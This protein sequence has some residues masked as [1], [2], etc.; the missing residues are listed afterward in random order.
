MKNLTTVF[1]AIFLSAS[2]QAQDIAFS[3]DYFDLE[4]SSFDTDGKKFGYIF[5]NLSEDTLTWY[6]SLE[7]AE[8]FPEEWLVQVCDQRLCYGA[9]NFKS[10]NNLPNFLSPSSS[11]DPDKQ[12]ILVTPQGVSGTSYVIFHIYGGED[13][14]DLLYSTSMSVSSDDLEAP[15]ISIF[16]NPVTDQIS[17]TNDA[18]ITK[19]VITALDGH[20]LYTM[21][22]LLGD[23][24]NIKHLTTG[25][26][27]IRLHDKSD[28]VVKTQKILKK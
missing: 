23:S 15:G 1:L 17:I 5:E 16:P 28:Q 3:P 4:V 27:I 11:T 6:W 26:Y 25:M 21:P 20:T 2:I 24:H 8:D 9:G 18:D 10:S 22:H 19:I 14:T 13:C 12:Y 7:L